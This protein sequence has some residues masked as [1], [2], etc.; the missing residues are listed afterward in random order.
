MS[1]STGRKERTMLN[2]L[3]PCEC[4]CKDL[5][6]FWSYRTNRNRP[7]GYAIECFDC[8]RR[9]KAKTKREAFLKWDALNDRADLASVREL[10]DAVSRGL[11]DDDPVFGPLIAAVRKKVFGEDA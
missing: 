2:E 10:A 5:R 8:H 7:D 6:D 3:L 9:I 1:K 4:G 11:G